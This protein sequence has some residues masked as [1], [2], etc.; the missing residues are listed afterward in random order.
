MVYRNLFNLQYN[1]YSIKILFSKSELDS[2]DERTM[3]EVASDEI[4]GKT[5]QKSASSRIA[6]NSIVKFYWKCLDTIF[7]LFK[8]E[9]SWSFIFSSPAEGGY[10]APIKDMNQ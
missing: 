9:Q 4:R 5:V 10:R 3:L 8:N 7:S 6:S 2:L 1:M